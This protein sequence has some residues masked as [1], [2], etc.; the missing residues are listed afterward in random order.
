MIDAGRMFMRLWLMSAAVVLG[1]GFLLM[2]RDSTP[3]NAWTVPGGFTNTGLSAL[4][5]GTLILGD[6][7]GSRIVRTSVNGEYLGEVLLEGAPAKSVQGVAWSTDTQSYWVAHYSIEAGSIR[8]YS[9]DGDLLQIIDTQIPYGP[10]GIAYDQAAGRVIAGFGGNV[11]H[12][13]DVGG[14]LSSAVELERSIGGLLDGVAIDPNNKSKL[15][16]SS[17]VTL[18]ISQIDRA[19]GA[20]ISSFNSPE[21]PESIAFL[22]GA[23]YICADQEHHSAVPG[24]NRVY[25]LD[26]QSGKPVNF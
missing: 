4:P 12:E 16:I 5:D 9:A 2:D 3:S 20:L 7:S 23:L 11:I 8:R 19:N 10:N 21:N 14:D 24:G 6:F 13:Y 15:W 25:R 17:D 18:K 1:I 26:P 22:D